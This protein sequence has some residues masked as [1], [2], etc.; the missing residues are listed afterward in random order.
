MTSYPVGGF[1]DSVIAVISS[2]VQVQMAAVHTRYIPIEE[3][4]H[5]GV[6]I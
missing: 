2:D 4:A 1:E 6:N 3:T 5:L